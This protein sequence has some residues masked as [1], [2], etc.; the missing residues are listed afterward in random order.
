MISQRLYSLFLF[1][2]IT[3]FAVAAF[4]AGAGAQA[5]LQSVAP[6]SGGEGVQ[7]TITATGIVSKPALFLTA[8][9]STKK[10]NLKVLSFTSTS[11]TATLPGAPAGLYD[12]N[13]KM[14]KEKAQLAGSVT[15]VAPAI[16]TVAPASGPKKTLVTITGTDFGL[17]KGKVQVGTKN[18][19]PKSWSDTQITFEIP[20]MTAATYD[21]KVTNKAGAALAAA[22]LTVTASTGGGGSVSTP[23]ECDVDSVHYEVKGNSG[24]DHLGVTYTAFL[25]LVGID[26]ET[27]KG[28]GYRKV[29]L[30]FTFDIATGTVPSAGQN[31][32]LQYQEGPNAN[33]VTIWNSNPG[34]ATVN[35]TSKNGNVYEGT[36]SGTL[37]YFSGPGSQT[38]RVITD[39]KFKVTIK[40]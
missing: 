5:S 38:A 2:I 7:V 32:V 18:A 27:T 36:F 20:S 9:G 10:Y 15:I 29:D 39:G 19:P 40:P 31:P 6:S 16:Q 1:V 12:L 30:V 28:G 8:S 26:T 3:F 22:A 4:A 34:D 11:V 21:V 35:L 37:S 13:L 23:F 17:K 25:T 14:K 33:N 24:G